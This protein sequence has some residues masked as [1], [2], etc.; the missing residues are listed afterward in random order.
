MEIKLQSPDANII[1]VGFSGT[2]KSEVAQILSRRLNRPVI[3]IDEEVEKRLN[4]SAFD[5]FRLFGEQKFREEESKLALEL[6]AEKRLIIAAG[7]GTILDEENLTA[8]DETGTVVCL[9]A[10][11]ETIERRLRSQKIRPLIGGGSAEER[12]YKIR[13]LKQKREQHYESIPVQIH[14]DDKTPEDVAEEI[15]K[16]LGLT[17]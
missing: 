17:D 4:R 8:L 9:R 5:I 10:T 13:K 3:D 7:G 11:P 2:G 1:L 12:L 6:A 14:T 15:L 16:I